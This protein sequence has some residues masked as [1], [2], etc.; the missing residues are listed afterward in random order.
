MKWLK[1]FWDGHGERLI[2]GGIAFAF[3]VYF[4]G[5]TMPQLKGAG[6]TILIGLAMTAFNK[7]R[8]GSSASGSDK[9]ADITGETDT[10]E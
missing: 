9:P 6:M 10:K 3:A 4:L 2:F 1:K 5:Q 7:A 8:G